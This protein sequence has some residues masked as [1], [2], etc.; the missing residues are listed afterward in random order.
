MI[1]R[2]AK[3]AK[4]CAALTLISLAVVHILPKVLKDEMFYGLSCELY[5]SLAGAPE[6][7][8]LCKGHPDDKGHFMYMS[9]HYADCDGRTGKTVVVVD[10]KIAS[11]IGR[12]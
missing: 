2:I 10:G 5:I 11:I 4:I 12:E 6:R 1:G 9:M 3:P 7:I 8:S